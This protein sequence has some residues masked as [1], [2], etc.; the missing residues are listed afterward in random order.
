MPTLGIIGCTVLSR[1]LAYLVARDPDVARG[2]VV[3]NKEGRKLG[4]M[5]ERLQACESVDMVEVD[6]LGSRKYD[7][8]ELVIWVNS[9]EMHNSQERMRN[10]M[11]TEIKIMAGSVDGILLLYG[12]CRCQTLDI[13]MLEEETGAPIMY[14]VDD[15]NVVVDDCIS[16]IMGSSARYLRTM[17]EH[18]GA[19]FITPGYVEGYAQR[20][21]G[22]NIVDLMDEIERMTLA[23]EAMD[24]PPLIKLD[25]GLDGG[26]EYHAMISMFARTFDLEVLTVP[27]GMGVFEGSYDWA[28]SVLRARTRNREPITFLAD[29]DVLGSLWEQRWEDRGH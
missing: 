6:R 21:D 28:R 13:G 29:N 1:E 18:K 14:L 9:S 2:V 16:A 7:D 5:L 27:C 3:D 10:A 12:Q 22:Q 4:G 15:S 19:F 11:T 23:F 8:D 25:H 24:R 26:A 17:K 20:M